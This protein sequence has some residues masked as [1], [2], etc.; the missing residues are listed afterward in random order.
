MLP[1]D[2]LPCAT[3]RDMVFGI[4]SF[5]QSTTFC[6]QCSLLLVVREN[7]GNEVKLFK[8]LDRVSWR[9]K[10]FEQ[11]EVNVGGQ[12]SGTSAS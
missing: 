6:S 1:A 5:K 3:A 10:A 4:L 2:P 7:P 11:C 12:R 9:L 8:V